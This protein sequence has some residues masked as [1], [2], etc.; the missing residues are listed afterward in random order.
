M[1]IAGIP[2]LLSKLMSPTLRHWTWRKRRFRL[3]CRPI[4]CDDRC[5]TTGPSHCPRT[6]R[7]WPPG[8]VASM[9]STLTTIYPVNRLPGS[10][11]AWFC[12]SR[13]LDASE[14]MDG[15]ARRAK[16]LE[17]RCRIDEWWG[18]ILTTHETAFR[19]PTKSLS[20]FHPSRSII[21]AVGPPPFIAW[22]DTKY[23]PSGD[24]DRRSTD[25]VP[26]HSL[27]GSVIVDSHAQS[28]V[29]QIFTLW[30]SLCDAKYFPTGSHVT[31][32]T[33][34]VC[35]F[36]TTIIEIEWKLFISQ[37]MMLLSTLQLANQRSCG[38]HAKSNMSSLCPRSAFSQRQFSDVFVMPPLPNT[39]VGPFARFQ[40]I[41]ILS[42]PADANIKPLVDQRTEFT[43]A[44]WLSIWHNIFGID[45]SFSASSEMTGH[46]FHTTT[47]PHSLPWPPVANFVPSGWTSMEKTHFSIFRNRNREKCYWN[48]HLPL[49]PPAAIIRRRPLAHFNLRFDAMVRSWVYLLS[50]CT[51]SGFNNFIF[52][53]DAASER[54]FFS[55][56][57]IISCERC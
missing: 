1:S 16:L 31:P 11:T 42:S 33:S 28:L 30:S 49:P 27:N 37:T 19:W 8:A 12:F 45:L 14:W 34:P 20:H 10:S 26:P 5:S 57:L 55:L 7:R 48:Y 2:C 9:W 13:A 53:C 36:S 15:N 22:A 38:D 23:S 56:F 35:P 3:C 39:A 52:T 25:V 50:W 51:H 4:E 18:E 41:T 46:K 17:K 32:L 44:K 40:S 29:R 24:H 6:N 54:N 47:R 43:H 21:C